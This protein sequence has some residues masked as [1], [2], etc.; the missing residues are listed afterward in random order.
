[1]KSKGGKRDRIIRAALEIISEHGFHA[2]PISLITKKAGIGAGTVYRYFES[3]DVLIKELHNEIKED[4]LAILTEGY[5]V[6]KTIRERYLHLCTMLLKYFISHPLHFRFLEQ[7]Y[8]SPYGISL[9][10]DKILR[11]SNEKSIFMDLFEEGINSTVMKPL[12]LEILAALSFGPLIVLARD[13]SFGLIEMNED[14][15][16]KSVEACWDGV[17]RH[18]REDTGKNNQR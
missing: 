15:I 5:S 8:N 9:R 13:S 12:P 16:K 6:E 2:S 1:M 3:K 18:I 11:R 7:Y 14:L 4:V 10:R 17:A